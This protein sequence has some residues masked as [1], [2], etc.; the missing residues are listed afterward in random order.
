MA[1]VE[2]TAT[3]QPPSVS[4]AAP[5]TGGSDSETGDSP[6]PDA[7]PAKNPENPKSAKTAKTAK[8]TK[9]AKTAK[10]APVGRSLTRVRNPNPSWKSKPAAKKSPRKLTVPMKRPQNSPKDGIKKPH[11]FKPGTVA[12]R[13]IKKQQKMAHS[14]MVFPR[15]SFNRLV[16]EIVQQETMNN[17][18]LRITG[19]AFE[20]LQLAAEQF[21]LDMFIGST[22]VTCARRRQTLIPEDIYNKLTSD[23]VMWNLAG[24]KIPDLVMER[25]GMNRNNTLANIG[26]GFA[27]DFVMPDVKK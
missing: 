21:A 23:S 14:K 27:N 1:A 8:I 11:R 24:Y 20:A 26:G 19:R 22:N 12:L 16:R 25:M 5:S 17:D 2:K 13:D 7:H 15:A 18:T 9:A 3:I 6:A 4:F 10:K